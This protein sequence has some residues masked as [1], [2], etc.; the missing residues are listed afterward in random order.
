MPFKTLL[1]FVC[2]LHFAHSSTCDNLFK[3]TK[4]SEGHT[5]LEQQLSAWSKEVV[6]RQWEDPMTRLEAVRRNA[7]NNRLLGK[8]LEAV[9]PDFL[10][11]LVLPDPVEFTQRLQQYLDSRGISRSEQILPGRVGVSKSGKFQSF[12]YLEPLPEGFSPVAAD[13]VLPSDIWFRAL[14]QGV[15]PLAWQEDKN[16]NFGVIL[17]YH[18]LGHLA[19]LT[20][21]PYLKAI[22]R[23][24]REV[25]NRID[26]P[27]YKLVLNYY[28][29]NHLGLQNFFE[30]LVIMNPENNKQIESF[31]TARLSEGKVK[32]INEL[33][34][35]KWDELKKMRADKNNGEV[36]LLTEESIPLETLF[37]DIVDFLDANTLKLGGAM[38][39]GLSALGFYAGP[40]YEDSLS[41]LSSS[42]P[43]VTLKYYGSV[44]IDEFETNLSRLLSG[45]Y[46]YLPEINLENLVDSF[47]KRLDGASWHKTDPAW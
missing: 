40:D 34:R 36:E 11:T 8:M 10:R 29:L 43:S 22:R 21:Y 47:L 4:H 24:I 35:K 30:D 37:T 45:V 20:Y 1:A 38:G 13:V 42:R 31:L 33:M 12:N 2:W 39:D 28:V 46:A 6:H 3:V 7:K 26:D 9:A 41:R 5:L 16:R 17:F 19:G 14:Q 18:E 15:L 25:I 44:E 32:T 23:L 27:S